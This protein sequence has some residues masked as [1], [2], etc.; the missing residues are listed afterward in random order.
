MA[1]GEQIA[2]YLDRDLIMANAAREAWGKQE[3][4]RQHRENAKKIRK[5]GSKQEVGNILGIAADAVGS[6]ASI[7]GTLSPGG[8][9]GPGGAAV[10]GLTAKP[11]GI[12]WV[13]QSAYINQMRQHESDLKRSGDF[14]LDE[15]FGVA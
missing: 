2:G 14:S 10:S 4:A 11:G 7:G 5:A 8:M 13:K 12:D 1:A 9:P 6:A 3:E 15:A